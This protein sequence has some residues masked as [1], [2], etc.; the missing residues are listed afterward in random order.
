MLFISSTTVKHHQTVCV[1]Y[2]HLITDSMLFLTRE[3]VRIQTQSV[4]SDSDQSS[5]GASS[6]QNSSVDSEHAQA[7]SDDNRRRIENAATHDCEIQTNRPVE[8][9]AAHVDSTVPDGGS[10]AQIDFPQ[11][12]Q[13]QEYEEERSDS[14]SSELDSEQTA[15]GDSTQREA[16]AYRQE[17]EAGGHEGAFLHTDGEWH[18]IESQE[19]EPQWQLSQSS[20]NSTRNRFTPPEDGVYRLELRE[21]LSR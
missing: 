18:V 5:S 7:V 6:A 9:E 4:T 20:S 17:P 16:E 21:L 15:P 19:Q 13:V 10:V 3:E 1:S 11:E 14:R 12:Q 8:D 2:W